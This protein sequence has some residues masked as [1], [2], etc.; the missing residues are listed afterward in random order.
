LLHFFP[1]KLPIIFYSLDFSSFN[2]SSLPDEKNS[3][4]LSRTESHIYY[5]TLPW[6]E[7]GTG[8]KTNAQ[9]GEKQW[10]WRHLRPERATTSFQMRHDVSHCSVDV[11]VITELCISTAY[12]ISSSGSSLSRNLKFHLNPSTLVIIVSYLLTSFYWYII[13]LICSHIGR[14]I[15]FFQVILKKSLQSYKGLRVQLTITLCVT[16]ENIQCM[17]ITRNINFQVSRDYH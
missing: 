6:E 14:E 15:H 4:K 16:C 3:V 12:R 17:K 8:V 5:Q 9:L 1:H 2:E 7:W 13:L 10:L 11:A